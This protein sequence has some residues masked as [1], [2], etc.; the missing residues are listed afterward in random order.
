MALGTAKPAHAGQVVAPLF[1]PALDERKL[2]KAWTLAEAVIIDLEDAVA[3]DRKSEARAWVKALS[4]DHRHLT[5]VRVNAADTGRCGE[6]ILAAAAN[7]AAIVLPKCQSPAD[8]R[9]A[10]DALD[11]CGSDI[12]LIPII[13][14]AAGLEAASAIARVAPERL[15]RLSLGLGDLSRDLGIPWAPEGPMAQHARCHLGIV[16][17]AAGLAA[18]LD[19]VVPTVG[20]VRQLT[21]DTARARAA[22]FG[23]KFC[24]HPSQVEVVQAGFRPSEAE[25]ALALRQV[26]AFVEA[27]ARGS[28]AVVVDGYFVD[29]PVAELA[30]AILARA[31]RPTGLLPARNAV[32]K[33]TK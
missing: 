11:A 16:S 26:Q 24:I 14:T 23:G 1:V 19:T 18:P 33:P 17:R 25:A 6:D 27:I 4:P 20:D 10:L 28:A 9:L 21:D 32:P 15:A 30:E 7:A 12:Q 2:H 8:L 5:W 13:E 3:D 31:G 29:Y 22:G